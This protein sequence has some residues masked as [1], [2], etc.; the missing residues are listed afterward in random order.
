M[1][2][3]WLILLGLWTVLPS[4]AGGKLLNV[5][6]NSK[7]HKQEPGPED[8]LYFECMPWKD[9]AC[10]TRDTSWEA[11]LDE[12]LLFNFSMTHCGL[13]TPLCHK[14]FIQAICFYE[15]SPNLGPWIQPVV[16][17]RQE[18]QRLWD[19][20][21]C[22]EDCEEWWKDC[23]TSHTCKA[24][25]LHGWV[26]DQV[27]SLLSIGLQFTALH[28]LHLILQQLWLQI[29]ALRL[30]EHHLV[31]NRLEQAETELSLLLPG[32]TRARIPIPAPYC[33]SWL[34]RHGRNQLSPLH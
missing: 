12:P 3:W 34:L 33:L 14:H 25:W 9:N 16:P 29:M 30:R 11:H 17:N 2:Q 27:K 8:K 28:L 20:P 13:L 4:L 7:H 15:C 23:R 19:V 31:A 21:L 1:A 5:C 18:E 26:W 22:L 24:D 6:M 10:C 32:P